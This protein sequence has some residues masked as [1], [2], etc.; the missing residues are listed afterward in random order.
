[1]NIQLSLKQSP[2]LTSYEQTTYRGHFVA[3]WTVPPWSCSPGGGRWSRETQGR[4]LQGQVPEVDVGLGSQGR[5]GRLPGLYLENVRVTWEH[6]H[7]L[8]RGQSYIFFM[9]KSI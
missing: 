3:F 1:M 5:D 7:H 8:P 2:Y 9:S 6:R 4:T